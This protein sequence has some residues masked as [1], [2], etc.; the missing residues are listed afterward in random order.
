MHQKKTEISK[1][2]KKNKK[3]KILDY[4]STTTNTLDIVLTKKQK[5][6]RN[7]IQK[8]QESGEYNQNLP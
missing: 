7:K 2:K 4:G 1:I 5:Y 8:D 6:V 3:T